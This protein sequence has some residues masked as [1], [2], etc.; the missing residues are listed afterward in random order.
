MWASCSSWRYSAHGPMG[1]GQGLPPDFVGQHLYFL[2]SPGLTVLRLHVEA[3]VP[4]AQQTGILAIADETGGTKRRRR[5][6]L[7]ED[8]TVQG[9]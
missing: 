6:K 8:S 7:A 1:S 5:K 9:P 4:L 2:S 3:S